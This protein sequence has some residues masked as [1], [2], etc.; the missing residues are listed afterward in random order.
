M[1]LFVFPV[2]TCC[3]DFALVLAQEPGPLRGA[4]RRTGVPPTR[5]PG[6][7]LGTASLLWPTSE[8][9]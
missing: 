9:S 4:R 8:V 1:V 5:G 6:W 3:V 7:T 2:Q